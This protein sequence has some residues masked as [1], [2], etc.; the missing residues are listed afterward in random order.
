VREK[1]SIL[2]NLANDFNF[3]QQ[4]RAPLVLPSCPATDLTPAPA[5]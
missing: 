4:P 2:G 1:A 5:C 3:N